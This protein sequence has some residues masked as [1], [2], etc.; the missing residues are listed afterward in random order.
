[1]S[2]D[3]HSFGDGASRPRRR[4]TSPQT[5]PCRPQAHRGLTPHGSLLIVDTVIQGQPMGRP[6]DSQPETGKPHPPAGLAKFPS[7]Q[8]VLPNPADHAKSLGH[9]W[10]NP[11]RDPFDSKL[12][13][14]SGGC[15]GGVIR[16]RCGEGG[17][18]PWSGVSPIG[19]SKSKS[20]TNKKKNIYIYMSTYV[21]MFRHMFDVDIMH[22]FGRDSTT[23]D[24][25]RHMSTAE[26]KGGAA[27]FTTSDMMSTYVD[28]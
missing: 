14:W 28:R 25:C 22:L 17:V 13:G 27:L 21:D 18:N 7:L 23:S 5:S 2:L 3:K 6:W 15:R 1:M 10:E 4:R 9:R 16:R 24:I 8:R 12:G 26:L 20:S 11:T 19:E